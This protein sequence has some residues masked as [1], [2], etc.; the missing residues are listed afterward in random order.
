MIKLTGIGNIYKINGF[1]FIIIFYLHII[2][3]TLVIDVVI[4]NRKTIKK[5]MKIVEILADLSLIT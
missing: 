3:I 1:I 4:L 2:K 5:N